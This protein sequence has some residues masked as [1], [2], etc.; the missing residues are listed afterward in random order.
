MI[1]TKWQINLREE[2]LPLLE[3]LSLR[4]PAAPRAFL[5]Q[6]CK[7]QRITVDN[8]IAE[9]GSCV[10]AGEIITVKT[11]RRWLECLEQS[12]LQ[13]EQLLYEDEQCIVLNKPTGLAIH[14]AQG[15]DDNLLWRVQDFLRLRSETFRVAPVHRL[16][17]GT[18]GAVL[19]GKGHAAISQLGK[20]IMA[21]QATKHYLEL[22]SGCI[23]LPGELNSAVPAK[24]RTKESLTRFRPVDSTDEFT[25]LE[26]EL[27]TGR[28][29]QIR[30][31]LAIAGWP[32]IGDTR[33]QGKVVNGM[34]HPFLHCHHLAFPQPTTG[35][36]IDISCPL[37]KDLRGQLKSLGFL[38]DKF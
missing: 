36:I 35:T 2:N 17:I 9:A 38:E 6:L 32:I 4:V 8:R 13:P 25:L 12:R 29:H 34:N 23:T 14:R 33:Y 16:D 28:H 26:L 3:A 5:R 10:R 30:H 24:G 7:K 27:V 1:I 21:G 19:F 37:S 11:S 15:H 18:S 31:Q 22:V 20:M